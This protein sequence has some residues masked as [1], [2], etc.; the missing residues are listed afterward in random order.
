MKP[1]QLT[2]RRDRPEDHWLIMFGDIRVGHIGKL[3]GVPIHAEQWGWDCGFY[4][5]AHRGISAGGSAKD[6]DQA[7]APFERA[8][9]VI[10]P[11]CTEP[12]FVEHR[13]HRASTSWKYKMWATGSKLPTQT[14]ENRSTCYCGAPITIAT[15][16][17]HIYSAHL[18]E[19]DKADA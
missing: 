6:F 3:A 12:D 8:W 11:R 15:M 10:L 16:S 7:R 19:Y 9:Q 4:P 17:E 13:R 5:A 14:A 18:D 1:L 2:R